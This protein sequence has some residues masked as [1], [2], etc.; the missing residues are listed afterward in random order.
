MDLFD[1]EHKPSKKLYV[2][3]DVGAS[4]AIVGI[5]EYSRIV[6]KERVPKIKNKKVDKR[7]LGD[8]F[9]KLK[10]KDVFI[11]IEDVHSI[12][13]A[14]AKSNFSFGGIKWMKEAFCMA[15]DLP[16]SLV[17]PKKWQKAIWTSSDMVYKKI[18]PRKVTD[19]KA[20]SLIAA[21]RLF[22]G[23]DFLATKISKVPH[24]GIVDAVLIAV[25][26]KHFFN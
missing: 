10:G 12:H 6:L 26:C 23:E 17:A 2:G 19:T 18:T 25:Y 24:D 20:T 15:F 21:K 8:I 9:K 5:D 1:Q 14:S 16:Y 7:A 3:V 11:M 13:G 4:G 22:P